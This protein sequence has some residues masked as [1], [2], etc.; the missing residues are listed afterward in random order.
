MPYQIVRSNEVV[1][2]RIK[3]MLTGPSSVGKTEFALRTFPDALIIDT[4][5]GSEV[6]FNK[7]QA[8]EIPP[9][10]RIPASSTD[11]VIEIIKDLKA[12]RLVMANGQ[13]YQTII[14]DQIS[15]LWEGRQYAGFEKALRRAKKRSQNVNEDDVM[16]EMLDWNAIKRPLQRLMSMLFDGTVQQHIILIARSHEKFEG[17]GTIA[18]SPRKK[19]T[20]ADAMQYQAQVE[21][22]MYFWP[23][24]IFEMTSPD[25]GRTRQ[26]KAVKS[27]YSKFVGG[28]FDNLTWADFADLSS[29]GRVVETPDYD[30]AQAGES[31]LDE[32]TTL[33]T[34]THTLA[35]LMNYVTSKNVP[36]EDF[37]AAWREN[38]WSGFES[39]RWDQYITAVDALAYNQEIVR[40]SE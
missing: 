4:E 6:A 40:P 2:T 15:T 36:T 14:I 24:L 23:H 38:G 11:T 17:T 28:T 31:A 35:E 22:G 16:V 34:T 19:N 10:D 39:G 27:R 12:G 29:V 20:V 26:F 13:P 7:A 5:A 9:F 37:R 33:P 25:G 30:T 3:M 21:K 1:Q 18:A 32:Q 8:G